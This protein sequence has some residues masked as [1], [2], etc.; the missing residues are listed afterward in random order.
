MAAVE[1]ARRRFTVEEFYQMARAGILG[2]NDRVELIDGEIIE[3]VP[4]GTRHA[5]CVR[6]MD[7]IFSTK[8]GNNA[9]VDT[10]NPLRLDQNSEPQPDLMLLKPRDDYYA[11]FHP[12]PE[13]VLLLVEVADTSVA[14]DREV[15]VNLYAKGGVNEVWLVN[16]Q[17]QQVTAYR[18]PSPSGYRE[19]KEYGRGD[20]ISLL[21]FPGLYIPV[22]DIIPG[23]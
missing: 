23:D 13:D 12:R 22:Q 17:V 6:R 7:R 9:L 21:A 18:L 8:I 2:E 10:Q 11:S 20:H 1:V 15:K 4:I 16:L 3:M 14:Y 5:A 19:I